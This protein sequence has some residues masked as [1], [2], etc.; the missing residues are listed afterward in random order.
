LI[1]RS[2]AR[3]SL[4]MPFSAEIDI[5]HNPDYVA[6]DNFATGYGFW[7]DTAHGRRD[8]WPS[9]EHF[10]Q[11]GKFAEVDKVEQIRRAEEPGI[12]KQLGRSLSGM[13]S[14]WDSLRR[15]RLRE[16]MREKFWAHAAPREVLL[17][18][19]ASTRIVNG[20]P[21]D[22]F[23][24]I[25]PDGSGA[26][27][28]GE[29]LM[30]LRQLLQ[31]FPFRRKLPVKVMGKEP[32]DPFS[33]FVDVTGIPSDTIP[34]LVANALGILPDAV[35]SVDVVTEGGF[36]KTDV[37]DVGD[38]LQIDAFVA[39]NSAD[40]EL[41]VTLAEA[42]VVT[43][44]NGTEDAFLCSGE[45][46]HLFP[47]LA[48]VQA[49]MEVLMPLL[50]FNGF[51]CGLTFSAD[52]QDDEELN[53]TCFVRMVQAA[54]DGADVLV[55]ARYVIPDS[56]QNPLVVRPDG[57]LG[58]P[59]V[60]CGLHT[61]LSKAE[62]IDR[63]RGLVWGAA[64]GDAVGLC[65][66]FMTKPDAANRYPDI[67][68]LGPASRVEDKHRSRWAQGDWT[69][70]T[71]QFVLLM[72]AI[73]A[74]GG[75]LNHHRF[76]QSLKHWRSHG[77]PELGDKSGLGIGQTVNEVLEHPAF[78]V[79]PD[80]AAQVAWRSSGC[81]MAANG[82]IMR[83]AASALAYFWDEE[84]VRYNTLAG[85][86]V[87]HADPRCAASCLVVALLAARALTGVT[88][89]TPDSR[90]LE[91]LSVAQTC[92]RELDGGDGDELLRLADIDAGG[93][94]SLKLDCGGIGYTFKPLA[95]A[96]W[97][98]V[99]AEDFKDAIIAITMEA[100]DADSNATV[101]GALLGVRMG[102]SQLPAEWLSAVPDL[103]RKWLDDKVTSCLH[104]L[105]LDEA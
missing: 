69:D 57:D 52:G 100:G 46:R 15:D 42:A 45:V 61:Q 18:I 5:F 68:K 39:K 99:H 60:D 92:I 37:A 31:D 38:V 74:S 98:F 55:S 63:V 94:S 8:W 28:I 34:A 6:L 36:E 72:D 49:R 58:P 79:A 9:A 104:A 44:W 27:A 103:Q 21:V 50:A 48:S 67:R 7:T 105:G 26:N 17:G 2:V 47:D 13:R 30:E 76:A 59:E 81:S 82:A 84:V 95:A 54:A 66:E 85:A 16:A 29:V 10:L 65:T 56:S 53:G 78:H 86:A 97:A 35:A 19:P 70:D 80:F 89:S 23:F 102:M 43:F 12:A 1:P 41:D 62:L 33:I 3:R 83:C 25:G 14:D 101:A 93:L 96:S 11:A 73:V 88:L 71:D 32:F 20:N 22:H 51:S 90:Q 87:T 24:G 4:P 75:V 64:L 40:C 91:F 77:F